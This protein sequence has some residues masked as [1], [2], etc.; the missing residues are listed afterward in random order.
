MKPTNKI[1]REVVELSAKLPKLSQRQKSWAM[2]NAVEHPALRI[3]KGGRIICT[4]CG[5]VYPD[6]L[7]LEE[8]DIDFCPHCFKKLKIKKSH[9]RKDRE[10]EYFSIVTTC[11]GWQVFRYF[12]I[13]K[14]CRVGHEASYYVDEVIQHWTKKDRSWVIMA[15]PRLMNSAYIADMWSHSGEL[16]IR[17]PNTAYD[18]SVNAVYPI[19][20]F[21]P[22]WKRYGIKGRTYGY[23]P[24]AFLNTVIANPKVETLLKAGEF[25]LLEY[26]INHSISK[27]NEY[28]ASIK[29]CI[30]NRYKIKD[31]SLWFDYLNLLQHFQKDL[32]N[33][34]YVCPK[35]L[36]GAHDKIMEK[37]RIEQLRE[38]RRKE[39]E[40]M[41]KLQKYAQTFLEEKSRFFDLSLSDG[42]ITVVV[43]KSLEEFKKEGDIMHHC[44]FTNEYFKRKDSLI[45]SARIGDK[46][47]ETI[48]VNLKRFDIVQSRAACNGKSEYH[49]RIV[50]LVKKNM[51]VIRQK[52]TA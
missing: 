9:A 51:N 49:N 18:V 12:Y 4:E 26:C 46:P 27:I 50:E 19:V 30:R 34:Y 52:M 39:I 1:Q 7:G 40:H 38:A 36:K 5:G 35:D 48:E 6:M 15:K 31:A 32:H 43:L 16:A 22:C 17:N 3:A 24:F 13:E 33:A 45:L 8:G 14:N 21:L 28:W 11:K 10:I 47:I 37:R 23:N 41:L 20:R 2:E 29:I 44:V 25:E 42:L